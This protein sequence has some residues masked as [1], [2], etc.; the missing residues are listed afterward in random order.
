[1]QLACKCRIHEACSGRME[2]ECFDTSH[3]FATLFI[4]TSYAASATA[5]SLPLLLPSPSCYCLIFVTAQP[6]TPHIS[7]TCPR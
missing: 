7:H 5:Q 4:R 2:K 6:H 3:T 1:M